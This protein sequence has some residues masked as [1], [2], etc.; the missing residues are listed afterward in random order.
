MRVVL[1]LLLL[2]LGCT[3]ENLPLDPEGA[4][5]DLSALDTR[6]R[7]EPD[8]VWEGLTARAISWRF[9]SF[10]PLQKTISA[11]G[12]FQITFVNTHLE[13]TWQ[14]QVTIRFRGADG[15]LHIPETP[16]GNLSVTADSTVAVRENFILEV[17]DPT[18]ANAIEQM[19]IVL[20]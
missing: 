14:S 6:T 18:A 8:Q 19:T 13:R 7:L 17:K 11:V 3:A 1:P 15:T 2:A 10:S 16:L 5:D 20:F 12:S 9:L 4:T